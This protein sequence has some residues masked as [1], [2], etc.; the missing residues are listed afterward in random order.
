MEI[1]VRN[2]S[3]GAKSFIRVDTFI[4]NAMI[5]QQNL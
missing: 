3:S 1:E 5:H 2:S 4:G